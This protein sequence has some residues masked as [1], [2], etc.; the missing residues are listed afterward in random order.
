[1]AQTQ[2]SAAGGEHERQ[3]EGLEVR[4]V[5]AE[6]G[7]LDSVR[8]YLLS[9]KTHGV[10]VVVLLTNVGLLVLVKLFSLENEVMPRPF[11]A[12]LPLVKL[13]VGVW[14]SFLLSTFLVCA[15]CCPPPFPPR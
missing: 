3:R 9:S 5:A 2:V 10:L 1:M 8:F 12:T 15:V 11:D 6:Q 13:S 14:P 7:K 4:F